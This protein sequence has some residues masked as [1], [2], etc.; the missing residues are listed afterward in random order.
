MVPVAAGGAGG[1]GGSLRFILWL[2]YCNSDSEPRAID[3]AH[4]QS[5]RAGA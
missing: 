2:Y 4:R 5:H 1:G 3:P